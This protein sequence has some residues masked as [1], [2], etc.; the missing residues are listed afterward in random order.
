M[1]GIVMMDLIVETD[2]GHDA[3]DFF[4]LCYLAAAG[5]SIRAIAVVPGDRDQ[6]A[7][8]RMLVKM[9]G[10][11]IPIGASKPDSRKC[12]SGGMHYALLDRFG[13]AREAGHDGPGHEIIAAT[14]ERHPGCEFL[15]IGPCTSTARHLARPDAVVP[16]RLTMQGGFLGY[17]LHAPSL[18]LPEFEGRTWMPTF[19]LNGDRRGADVL[20]NAA[21]PERRFVGKNVCHTLLYDRAFHATMPAAASGSPAQTLFMAGMD[22]YLGTH[23]AKKWHDPAAAALHLH[24]EIGTWV[25]G[26]VSKIEGGWGTLMD[27][28]GDR[29]LADVDRDALWSCFRNWR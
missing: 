11:D 12:S 25:R 3:D 10:L 19:N 4:T 22:E 7:V 2:L 27:E 8:A 13:F 21:I 16:R 6:L 17:H 26:R 5:V 23:E 15:V 14:L 20:L 29:I 9:L 28:G 24:P 1:G 18:W